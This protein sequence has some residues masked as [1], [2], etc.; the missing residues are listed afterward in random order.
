MKKFLSFEEA[1]A[2]AQSLNLKSLKDWKDYCK[3][4]NKPNNIPNDPYSAYKN[5]NWIS[6]GD[7]LGTFRV[8]N[9][10][11]Q[12]I[13]FEEAKEIIKKLNLKNRKDYEK[14]QSDMIEKLNN[15]TVPTN[16][17]VV[18]SS[19]WKSWN[20]FLGIEPNEFLPFEEA[21]N[22]VRSLNLKSV[23]D[24]EKY[25]KQKP[26]NIPSLPSS[27]YKEKWINWGD[28]LGTNNVATKYVSFEDAK[29]IV[30][31]LKDSK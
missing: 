9:R 28:W 19:S 3:S 15:A 26:D 16:P 4:G 31:K 8:S 20:D 30:R 21:R 17:N 10:N 12:F 27:Y 7:W 5:N 25:R 1:K 11:K 13:S 2:F 24:W 6:W 29:N 14:Y 22:F 18:Y 23:R